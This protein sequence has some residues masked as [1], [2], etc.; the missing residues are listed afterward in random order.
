M[1]GAEGALHKRGDTKERKDSFD[2]P[3]ET[4]TCDHTR[5]D[6]EAES[7]T[8]VGVCAFPDDEDHRTDED[9]DGVVRGDDERDT[10]GQTT[11]YVRLEYRDFT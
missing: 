11:W 6:R 3:D 7:V 9:D 4:F 2:D 1:R 10:N 5:R 8:A